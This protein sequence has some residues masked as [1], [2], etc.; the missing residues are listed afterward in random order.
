MEEEALSWA[1]NTSRYKTKGLIKLPISVFY[2]YYQ[3]TTTIWNTRIR[4][5]KN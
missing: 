2:Y 1:S 5:T 4:Q 3:V